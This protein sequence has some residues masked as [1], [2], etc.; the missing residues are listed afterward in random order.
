MMLLSAWA[1]ASCSEDDNE[2]EEYPDWQATNEAYFD[3]LSDSVMALLA[4]DPS[5]TDWKRIKTWTKSEETVGINADYIIVHVLDPVA[6]V[7]EGS[8]L[9]TDTAKV[10]YI[11]RLLPSTTYSEG[12]VFDQTY[13]GKY[14]PEVSASTNFAV[15]NSTGSSPVAGFSTA[16]QHMRR[17]ERWMVYIPYQLGYGSSANGSIPAY[18]TMIFDL[19][20]VDFWSPRL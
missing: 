12:L 13:S 4:A 2:V 17:G 6:E 10:S 14:D 16:L 15:G 7:K 20:L 11:G 18:S 1:V 8:P 3:H 5:R 9:Y 19:I